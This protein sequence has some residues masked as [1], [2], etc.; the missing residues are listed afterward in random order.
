[1]SVSLL[2]NVIHFTKV[3]SIKATVQESY[4]E[5]EER[6][7]QLKKGN[8]L[9]SQSLIVYSSDFLKEYINIPF[10]DDLREERKES[11]RQYYVTGFDVLKLERLEEF[12]GSRTINNFQLLDVRTINE[13]EADV[14]FQV[15]YTTVEVMEVQQKDKE[16]DKKESKKEDEE[17]KTKHQIEIIIPVVTDGEGY[18]V[19]GLPKLMSSD[20]KSQIEYKENKL[21][22]ESISLSERD[23][24]DVFLSEFFNVYGVS[25]DILAFMANTNQGLIG[26]IYMEHAIREGVATQDGFRVIV[27]VTYRDQNVPLDSIYSFDLTISESNNKYF[28]QK[29]N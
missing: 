19:T 26:K 10:E 16:K 18:A 24:L 20:F 13:N 29:I 1:M 8:L 7:E 25:E 22:G 12:A 6:I 9:E 3:E 27:D 28:V 5:V 17:L 23:S 21:E 15:T 14:H 2:F 11:L 4:Q